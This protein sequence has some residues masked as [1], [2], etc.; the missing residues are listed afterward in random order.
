MTDLYAT[1]S[2]NDQ[3]T[4]R[5]KLF[6]AL[7]S[8]ACPGVD[9]SAITSADMLTDPSNRAIAIDCFQQAY[10]VSG[11]IAGV[12]DQPTYNALVGWW[13][14][15]PLWIKATIIGGGAAAVALAWQLTRQKRKHRRLSR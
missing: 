15:Q 12:L 14:A 1:L 8:R 6:T 11:S 10:N 9:V 13:S 4:V 3:A 7:Q 5:S 2:T